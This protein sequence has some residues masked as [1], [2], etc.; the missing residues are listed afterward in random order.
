MKVS[1]ILAA[2]LLGVTPPA[3]EAARGKPNTISLRLS[4]SQRESR[5]RLNTGSV[6]GTIHAAYNMFSVPDCLR[7]YY[8]GKLL[9]D[10][11]LV[12]GTGSITITYGPG[13]STLVEIVM[14]E[15]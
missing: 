1:W 6:S 11:G 7:I 14:N 15:G 5:H 8:D 10:T 12:S 9:Y 2:G 4:A 3:A 13:T